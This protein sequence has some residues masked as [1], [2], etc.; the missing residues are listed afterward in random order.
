MPAKTLWIERIRAQRRLLR[1]E[2]GNNKCCN[3]GACKKLTPSEYHSFYYR[4]KGN[5]FK[6]KRA[7]MEAISNM[8]QEKIRQ[9]AME[10]RNEAAKNANLIRNARARALKQTKQ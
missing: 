4:V 5:Q 3:D 10:S 1:H 7:L 6:H 8:R 9:A 2:R